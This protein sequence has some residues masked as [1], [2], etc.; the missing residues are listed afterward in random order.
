MK[1]AAGEFIDCEFTHHAGTAVL[2]GEKAQPRFER[3]HVR[4]NLAV[5]VHADDSSP[6]FVACVIEKNAG[7]G[8]ACTQN[9]SPRMTQGEI[10]ENVGGLAI[11]SHGRGEWDQVQFFD[12]RADTVL[13]AEGGRPTLRVCHIERAEGAGIRFR[14]QGQGVIEDVDILGS[15]GPGIAIEA[16]ANPSLKA[17]KV[18]LGKGP[19]IVVH[20]EGAGR[21]EAC[22]VAENAGGDWVVDPAARLVRM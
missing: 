21:A 2:I 16:G 20:A 17:V 14:A 6:E 19:G 4:D 8:F 3:C 7:N 15:E 22:E 12:N 18:M 5:G 9:A 13:V 10:A 1:G 11:G